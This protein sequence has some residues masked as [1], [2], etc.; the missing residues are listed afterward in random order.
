M[1]VT[2]AGLESRM[3]SKILAILLL[4]PLSDFARSYRVALTKM[5]ASSYICL[6]KFNF[7]AN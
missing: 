2:Q 6:F 4:F 7:Y 5:V 3:G 1:L